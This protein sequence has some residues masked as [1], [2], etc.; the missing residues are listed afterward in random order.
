VVELFTI[1]SA[2][3]CVPVTVTEVVGEVTDPDVAE[4]VFVTLP[5]SMSAW[6]IV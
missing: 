6:V 4:A 3:L 1:A 5:A 2:G